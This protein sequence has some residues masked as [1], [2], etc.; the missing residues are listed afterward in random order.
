MNQTHNIIQVKI[1]IMKFTVHS[2]SFQ[3]TCQM[4]TLQLLLDQTS[5]LILQEC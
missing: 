2:P 5:T 4:E 3:Y 1:L